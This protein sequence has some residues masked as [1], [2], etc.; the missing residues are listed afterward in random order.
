MNH[1]MHRGLWRE[2][3]IRWKDEMKGF[4]KSSVCVNVRVRNEMTKK[5]VAFVMGFGR[6]LHKGSAHAV[7]FEGVLNK[8]V[9]G[10]WVLEAPA[11]KW[12]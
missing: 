10:G 8:K 9:F 4:G 7:F 12:E 2:R 5:G 11:Q 1:R 3:K 6:T